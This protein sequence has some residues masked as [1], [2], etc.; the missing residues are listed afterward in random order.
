MAM[1]GLVLALST[2]RAEGVAN[3]S[4]YQ[5]GDGH[6]FY[7]LS[8]SL[9][10]QAA[11][12][13]SCDVVVLFDTSASQ[14]GV[15][16]ETALAAL[17]ACAAKLA[18]N[19]RVQLLAVDLDAR[20]MTDE[21]V[22]ARSPEFKAAIQRLKQE[23]PLGS[24]DLEAALLAA[25]KRFGSDSSSHRA[26]LYI[27]D[28]MSTANLLATES[29]RELVS[30]L[31]SARVPVSSYAIGPRRDG[32]LLA[33]LANQSG[34][35]L[36][37]DDEMQFA[38]D[39]QGISAERAHDENLRRGAALGESLAEWTGATVIWPE[40]LAL[41]AELGES[42]PKQTPPLRSDRDTIVI[43]S[44]NEP[45]AAP[46]AI[47]AKARDAAGQSV[48]LH[49]VAEALPSDDSFAYLEQVVDAARS[50]D[51]LTLP[52]IGSAGLAETARMLENNLDQMT[53]LAQ[54][55]IAVGDVASANQ[56]SRAILRRD[57]G[58]VRAQ[59]V[60]RVVNKSQAAIPATPAAMESASANGDLSLVRS[61]QRDELP[62]LSDGA[63]PADGAIVDQ[64]DEQGAFL[65]VVEEQRRVFAQMLRR[66]VEN[67]VVDARRQM[68]SE[69]D[70]AARQL[71]LALQNVER[72]P[73]LNA[74]VRA[75]LSDRLVI[76]LR[77]VQRMAAIK[78]ELD[79][80]RE[81]QL[82][83]ARER[84][85]LNARLAR[86]I[87]RE[88][89]LIGR[90]NALMDERRYDE[91][92][93]VATIVEEVDPEGVVPRVAVV[94]SQLMRNDYL[95]QI[96]RAARWRGFFDTLYPVEISSIP[97]PDDPP[98][99]YPAAP[100]WEE[101]T[102]RRKKF[103][104]V[105]LKSA[106]GA[107][108]RIN[109][110]L[111]SPLQEL[112]LSFQDD[113]LESVVNVLQTD[114]DI[115]IQLDVAALEDVGLSADEPITI[116]IQNVTLRSALR[117]M[118][119]PH[120]LTYIIQDEVMIIT[121]PDEA[122]SQLVAKVYPVA[123]LVLPIE[124]P[125]TGGGLGGGGGAMGGGGGGG[126]LGGGGGGGFG[127][128]GGGGGG[129]L[130]GGGGGMF[131]VPDDDQANAHVPQAN[132][133]LKV[134]S[135]Q[136]AA[137]RSAAVAIEE[138]IAPED[139]WNG[140]FSEPR[141]PAVVRAT[142]RELMG[143][144]KLDQAIALIEAALRNG[145]PQPWMYESL[146]IALELAGRSKAEIERVVMSAA[147]FS[148]TPDELMYIATYLSRIGLDRRAMQLCQQVVKLEPLRSEAYALGL[149]A[150]QR[151]NDLSGIEWATVGVLSQ[152]WPKNLTSIQES[153]HHLAEATLARLQNE[154][155][156]EELASYR[157]ALDAAVERDCV[158][159][160]S[161][162][163]NADVDV[164]V[165]EPSGTICS[166]AEP[167][168][169]AG[170]VSL[171]D[172]FPPAN[173]ASAAVANETYV[174][175]RGFAGTYRVRI[176]RVWGEVTAGKVTVD[177]YRH[178]GSDQVEHERRQ[179]DLGEKDAMVVFDLDAGRRTEPL[180]TA[181]LA[182]AVQRQQQM[183]RSVLAQQIDSLSD[184]RA[185]PTDSDILRRRRALGAFGLNGAVGYQPIIT[186]LPEGTNFVVT[187]VVSADRRYVR[188]TS[189]PSFT[190]IGDVQTFTFAGRAQETQNGGG[191]AGPGGAGGDGDV[192]IPP[193][194]QGGGGFPGR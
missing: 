80:A 134:Q 66:E 125:Q 26:I 92:F 106:G 74:E 165:E 41:P 96:T 168:T 158:V 6:A 188:I 149:H 193:F 24:T 105:D 19:D 179:L 122:E 8:L 177:V 174:C 139:F 47:D 113:P 189:V 28:G 68:S 5:P 95:Q 44:T 55:A 10:E 76:A 22:P 46:L 146:G 7:A 94:S 127:G 39:A 131:S 32:A 53:E 27:G 35:N 128:G 153:A 49:W 100:E 98:I 175:P 56:I 65:D 18:A 172:A 111:S 143:Q 58:N 161:W 169:A 162:T 181:Q 126:G 2:A 42:F 48:T 64:F 37:V 163:G 115:P 51:G 38:D 36:Y 3:L 88:K 138:S 190:G 75:Q 102:N 12:D 136:H 144:K 129:G 117:L 184:P 140:Y 91:A 61:A 9:P 120:Q 180:E 13:R 167:R 108:E 173:R 1:L 121:T 135:K 93:E 109:N 142:A 151:C 119:K 101:L 69:P 30:T 73:E 62:A 50:D 194:N 157:R 183:S 23:S 141:E 118:L 185:L 182:G 159:R 29:F 87:E 14:T 192:V 72:A 40:T 166:S 155:L 191:G 33:A 123:D 116:T 150:A 17:E 103:A 90:Y 110:A 124:I 83:V 97:F 78:D 31:Q 20:P 34:G 25:V 186:T 43:G 99:I 16:R 85:L 130:G 70:R 45:L 89:Q 154:G 77:E 137:R 178:L 187:G 84:Q 114:Y 176:H 21:F 4:T 104:S 160:V 170:G 148:T 107:E 79:A 147:D 133:A 67:V 156:H 52:T 54:R 132:A 112:G 71:K 11:A 60:Q 57:P 81:E 164:E 63:F 86:N 145:Q 59:T 171:G 82:A 15:Y 152:A